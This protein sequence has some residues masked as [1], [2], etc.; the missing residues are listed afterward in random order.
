MSIL[1]YGHA[2]RLVEIELITALLVHFATVHGT[3]HPLTNHLTI[4]KSSFADSDRQ[5]LLKTR[6]YTNLKEPETAER[7]PLSKQNESPTL[8]ITAKDALK[9]NVEKQRSNEKKKT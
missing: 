6:R 8:T 4:Q 7:Q 5:L 9:M 2:N 1:S 3:L